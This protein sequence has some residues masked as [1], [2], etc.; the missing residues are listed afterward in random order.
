MKYRNPTRP[1]QA[2][3]IVEL[4]VAMALIIFIMYILAEAFAAGTTAFRNLKAIGDM[5]ERLRSASS[6]LRRYLQ[7]DHFEGR[8]RLSDLDFWKNGP[9][10]E[11]FFR[12]IQSG[13]SVPEGTDLDGLPSFRSTTQALH[14]SVKLRGNARGDY[15]R[16]AVPLGSPLLN[17]PFADSRFQD[18][19]DQIC[20]PAAEVAI[21]LRDTLLTTEDVDSNANVKQNLYTMY[22]RQRLLTPD[23]EAVKRF[24]P[25]GAWPVS[26]ASLPDHLGVGPER[27]SRVGDRDPKPHYPSRFSI[28][29]EAD[30]RVII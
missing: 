16:G 20:S 27:R 7:A 9:P 2:F 8:K 15:Y 28:R 1:R 22:L 4:M 6:V 30:P 26:V 29:S 21:Y 11:G 14:F 25:V 24:S 10:Q 17:L 18:G 23:N 5:N 13:P 12:I 3:T 19:P